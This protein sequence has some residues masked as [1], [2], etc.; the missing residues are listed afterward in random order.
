LS[1]TISKSNSGDP[2]FLPAA[3]GILCNREH[4]SPQTLF[5]AWRHS[6]ACTV[7]R[8]G[9]LLRDD[10]Y[11]CMKLTE[12]ERLDQI[13]TRPHLQGSLLVTRIIHGAHEQKCRVNVAGSDM[14]EE[15]ETGFTRH[16]DIG[17]HQ[18]E[19]AA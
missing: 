11:Y 19:S 10:R 9:I 6:I 14:A 17:N 16:V 4:T 8:S 15:I 18:I 5:A 3:F 12:P 1:K 7:T 13:A 2:G